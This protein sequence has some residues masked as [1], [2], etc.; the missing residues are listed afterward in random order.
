MVT[1]ASRSGLSAL[2]QLLPTVKANVG[3]DVLLPNALAALHNCSLHADAMALIATEETA[4]AVLPWLSGPPRLAR[5]AAAVVAKCVVRV[6]TAVSLLIEQGA[7]PPLIAALVSEGA[8]HQAAEEAPRIVDVTDAVAAAAD[9]GAEVEAEEAAAEEE[10]M[11]GSAVR[12]LAACCPRPEAAT[13][14]CEG[15]GLPALAKLLHRED[16]GMQGNAALCIAEC[17]KEERCLLVLAVQPVVPPL[18]AIAHNQKGQACKNAAIALGRLAK[19]TRCLQQIR[20]NHGI[21][22][23]ARAMK[24]QLGNMGMAA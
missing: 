6:P 10:E 12:I 9:A 13:M 5:R 14:V 23:L 19:N 15:G 18:L 11:V 8:A 3:Q 7:L 20:D 1:H 17:A 22:I 4:R 24:G 21:E 16:T 2:L